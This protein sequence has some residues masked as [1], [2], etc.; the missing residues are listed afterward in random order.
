[1]VY[2][3][4]EWGGPRGVSIGDFCHFG[5]SKCVFWG[6]AC[7]E[8]FCGRSGCFLLHCNVLRGTLFNSRS[9]RTSSSV[10]LRSLTFQADCG[11][12]KGAAVPVEEDA[13]RYLPWWWTRD[14]FSHCQRRN[15]ESR[16]QLLSQVFFRRSWSIAPLPRRIRHCWVTDLT[17][18]ND[19]HCQ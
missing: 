3:G 8:A 1:M 11:S 12:I 15:T 4:E 9:I 7:F 2:G 18:I 17:S 19:N 13:E 6:N 10:R 16:R 5:V 14:K